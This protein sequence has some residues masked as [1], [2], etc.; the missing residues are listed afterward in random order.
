MTTGIRSKSLNVYD[1]FAATARNSESLMKK[2]K[3][4]HHDFDVQL[5][6]VRVL[7]IAFIFSS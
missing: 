2:K 5:I 1:M 4:P 3:W 7:L 6:G